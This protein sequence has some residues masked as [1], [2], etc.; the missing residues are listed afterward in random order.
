MYHN[1]LRLA[2]SR[3]LQSCNRHGSR[4]AYMPQVVS[5]PLSPSCSYPKL[6]KVANLSLQSLLPRALPS[7]TP[8]RPSEGPLGRSPT[9]ILFNMM[10]A[11]ARQ[12]LSYGAN[13]GPAADPRL[14]CTS[15]YTGDPHDVALKSRR[16]LTC[17]WIL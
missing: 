8:F 14:Y 10:Q 2:F 6:V 17:N 3:C 4:G 15:I 16:T 13:N 12:Y 7:Y 11:E 5:H 9:T 1:D